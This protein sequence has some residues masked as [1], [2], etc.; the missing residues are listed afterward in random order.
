[1]TTLPD[2]W[3]PA[4]EMRRIHVH[5]TAGRHVPNAVDMRSYHVLI[6]GDGTPVRGDRSIAANAQGST[7]TP[8]SHTRRANTGA[9]GVSLCGMFHAKPN[10]FDPGPEPITQV[11]WDAAVGVVAQ[12]AR[13]YKIA[14]TPR[15]ILTHAEVGP[16]LNIPQ[17]GKWDITRL[18]FDL[19]LE[20][21]HAVGDRLRREVAAQL[22]GM[23]GSVS[24]PPSD[25]TLKLPR[26]KVQGVGTSRLNF[27]RSPDGE[28]VGGLPEG[29]RVE[30]LAV[31]GDW[32]QV[33]TP[34]GF[35]GWVWSSYLA[36]L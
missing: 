6:R 33:R 7:D 35:V 24:A 21:A 14:V 31:V 20:G 9:I 34:A 30:R 28:V 5:W 2:A 19:G 4:V 13:R 11:Q 3:M 36:A 1:M 17:A 8:A 15:T 16:N 22:D 23:P 32:W 12:L 27:R 26:F 10:P 29:T 18:P 25:P